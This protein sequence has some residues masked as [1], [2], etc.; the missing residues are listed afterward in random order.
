MQDDLGRGRVRLRNHG[1]STSE[2]DA[3]MTQPMAVYAAVSCLAAM[4]ASAVFTRF[5]CWLAPK[6]GFV[7]Q[8][9]RNR[10]VHK[11]ATPLGGGLAIYLAICLVLGVNICLANPWGLQVHQDWWDLVVLFIA[12]SWIVGLGLIDDW[13]RLRGRYKLAGQFVA[14]AI[15]VAG[16]YTFSSF[17][18]FGISV[19]LGWIGAVVALFWFLAT[20]NSINLLDGM[21]GQAAT[22]GT[23]FSITV[24]I[25]ACVTGHYAV[26]FVAFVLAGA[27]FGF[28]WFNLP[29][30]RIFLGDAGSMLIGLMLGV[31]AARASLKGPSTFLLAAAVALWTL[32]FLD[33]FAAIIRRTLSGR[34]IYAAD[35]SHIHH[36]LMEKC[37]SSE[38][39]LMVISACAAVTA[40]ASLGG[41]VLG[42]DTIALI[43]ASGVVAFLIVTGLFGRSECRLIL[44]TLRRWGDGLRRWLLGQEGKCLCNGTHFQGKFDWHKLWTHLTDPAGE[45][46]VIYLR[47]DLNDPRIQEGYCGEWKGPVFPNPD[48]TPISHHEFPLC[49]GDRVVGKIKAVLRRSAETFLRDLEFV[50]SLVDPF[51][52]QLEQLNDERASQERADKEHSVGTHGSHIFKNV[53]PTNSIKMTIPGNGDGNGKRSLISHGAE[54]T[55]TPSIRDLSGGKPT[56]SRK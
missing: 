54:T 51:E 24:G 41:L 2:G 43:A 28:L 11:K 26:A 38:T 3:S 12:G 20:I 17:R 4:I 21:D 10:K 31:L 22:L 27:T 46:N 50:I 7:D 18:L 16:G 56:E 37:K 48:D 42:N 39:A 40:V 34:S 19:E 15:L 32:P 55:K 23:I 29:P 6:I 44:N 33:C 25:M 45:Y 1:D 14:A 53:L 36:C 35:R 5:M 52:Q 13:S 47:V 30:A 9:D 8:P 49:T